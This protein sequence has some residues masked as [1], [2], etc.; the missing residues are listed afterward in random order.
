MGQSFTSRPFVQMQQPGAEWSRRP[1]AGVSAQASAQ[2]TGQSF[3]AI[4]APVV[5]QVIILNKLDIIKQVQ[6]NVYLNVFKH[7]LKVI[8]K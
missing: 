7:N 6:I 5:Q 2:F 8:S 3:G 4:P 1:S